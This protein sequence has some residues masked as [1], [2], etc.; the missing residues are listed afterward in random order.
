MRGKAGMMLAQSTNSTRRWILRL[1]R[2]DQLLLE[3]QELAQ[4]ERVGF[5]SVRGWAVLE[6][7]QIHPLEGGARRAKML[8]GP[9]LVSGISG[10]MGH[11][12][13]APEA[14]L[15][16]RVPDDEG[17]LIS[18]VLRAGVAVTGEVFVESFDDIDAE[19]SR[20]R[21]T[22]FVTFRARRPMLQPKDVEPS[23]EEAESSEDALPSSWA[24]VV[25]ASSVEEKAVE[26]APATPVPPPRPEPKRR[27][28]SKRAAGRVARVIAQKAKSAKVPLHEPKPL[29]ERKAE[30]LDVLLDEPIPERGSSV[31][32]RQL[33]KC[34]VLG[35]DDN[36]DLL[37][38][39]PRGRQ[40]TLNLDLMKVLDPD[41]DEDG[42]LLYPVIPR[43]SK[44]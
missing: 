37:I 2:G 41:L 14:Q 36:G 4:Q 13:D 10:S 32:H 31:Q 8:E 16:V 15:F 23:R 43:S 17:R 33:G 30:G 38:R 26:S 29:P 3:L 9:V 18:G 7:L 44:Q 35:E 5:A 42:E 34:L 20:D 12:A 24:D 19:R 22:G 21:N 11:V 25:L 40:R 27:T 6:D 1:E 28:G 39:T